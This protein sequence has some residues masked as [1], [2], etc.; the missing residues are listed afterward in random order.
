MQE[1]L[2]VKVMHRRTQVE[3]EE[4]EAV[5]WEAPAAMSG[6]QIRKG[7][8]GE[9]LE[10]HGRLWFL[11]DL[12][13]THDVQVREPLEDTPLP[14]QHTPRPSILDA[15]RTQDLGD[16]A[17]GPLLTPDLIDVEGASPVDVV[18]DRVVGSE[19]LTFA[20]WRHDLV[21]DLLV[22]RLG[23][24]L[25]HGPPTFVLVGADASASGWC[26]R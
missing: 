12:V 3:A 9:R 18:R 11:E 8:P 25:V 1:A 14:K 5:E 6:D 22:P 7:A 23:S 4:D 10:D 26:R 20:Q 15:I 2:S 19:E 13:G 16:A 21:L 24:N 17:A